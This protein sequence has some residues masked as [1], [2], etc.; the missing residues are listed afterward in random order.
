MA[1]TRRVSR[2]LRLIDGENTWK[3]KPQGTRSILRLGLSDSTEI[4]S[5]WWRHRI[6]QRHQASVPWLTLCLLS[7]LPKFQHT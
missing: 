4:K 2:E 7:P 6:K 5:E 1:R 3:I